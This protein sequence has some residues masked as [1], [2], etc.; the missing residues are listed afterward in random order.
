[1]EQDLE[2]EGIRVVVGKGEIRTSRF[3]SKRGWRRSMSWP[4]MVAIP[5]I[6]LEIP[7]KI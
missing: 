2:R 5:K 3:V 6:G 7:V 4:K 1:M